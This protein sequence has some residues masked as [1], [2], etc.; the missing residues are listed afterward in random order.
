MKVD[1]PGLEARSAADGQ[2]DV[3]AHARIAFTPPK[4]CDGGLRSRKHRPFAVVRLTQS[5]EWVLHSAEST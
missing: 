2:D 3:V 4:L 5:K 1:R